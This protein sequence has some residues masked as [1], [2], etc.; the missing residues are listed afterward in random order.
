MNCDEGARSAT[1]DELSGVCEVAARIPVL[2]PSSL[3]D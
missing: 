3:S 1:R 2:Q